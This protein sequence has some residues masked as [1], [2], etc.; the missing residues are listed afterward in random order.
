M[1]DPRATLRVVRD[2][3]RHAR[4]SGA[5]LIFSGI[6]FSLAYFLDPDHGPARRQHALE[7]ISRARQVMASAKW[8]DEN[9]ALTHPEVPAPSASAEGGYV[10]N[11][12]LRI[13]R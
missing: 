3:T 13:A 12:A 8:V 5:R 4:R 11:D 9:A 1:F 7:F 2:S 6:G 10:A